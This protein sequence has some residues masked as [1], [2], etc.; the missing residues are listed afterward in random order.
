M[1]LVIAMPTQIYEMIQDHLFQDAENE[2]ALE[3]ASFLF[4]EP[5]AGDG[6]LRV[7]DA[8]LLGVDDFAI[9][10]PLHIDLA[11][12][13]RPELI[14]RALRDDACLIETHSHNHAGPVAFSASDRRG[15]QEWVPHM[16]WRLRRRPYVA[17]VFSFDTFDGLCWSD[18]D[19]EPLDNLLLDGGRRIQPTN[20]TYEHLRETD[21]AA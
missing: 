17:L 3:Q 20:R 6:V 8:R 13:V 19:A 16:R 9:Q 12:H 10:T 2:D 14:Q 1:S 5:Y 11:E 7:A 18:G 4:T 15:F 21:R